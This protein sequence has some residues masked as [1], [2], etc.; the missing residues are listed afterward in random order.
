MRDGK[1]IASVF[2]VSLAYAIAR[3]NVFKG[4][5][6]EHLP[7]YVV[8]KAIAVTA[9]VLLGLSR[10]VFEKQRRKQ[11]GL[12]A[13]L[14]AAVH[15]M[16][17]M[18]VLDPYYMPSMYT[19]SNVMTLETE[20]SMLSG[21]LAAGLLLW[22]GYATAT[23]PLAGQSHGTS[24]VLGL[25]RTVLVLLALHVAF[26]GIA[27]WVAPSTWPGGMPPLTLLS[28]LTATGFCLLPRAGRAPAS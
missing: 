16:L 28:F 12:V 19:P 25:G 3:Y 7:V 27:G 5:L 11:L 18:M 10:R 17:S 24:L 2:A 20:L 13:A 23:H 6:W 9:V 4:V 14:L 22:L 1:L 15:V 21:T 26:Y 8:N